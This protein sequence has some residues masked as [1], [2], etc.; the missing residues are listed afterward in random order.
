MRRTRHFARSNSN[1]PNSRNIPSR[2]R[3]M[4][5]AN[6]V[7]RMDRLRRGRRSSA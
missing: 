7:G 4:D 3:H 5:R 2:N 1:S 6:R